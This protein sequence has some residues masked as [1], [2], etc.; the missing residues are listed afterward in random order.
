[1]CQFSLPYTG[2]PESLLRRA[3]QEIQG[4]G[5]SFDGDARRGTFQ[6]KTPL[7]SIRGSYEISGQQIFLSILKKPFL[8]SCKRIES[9]LAAFMY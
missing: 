7:G 3:Q 1:M 4:P 8:L 5:G 2:D 9:E 6:A